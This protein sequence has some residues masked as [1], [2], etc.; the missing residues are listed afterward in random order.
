MERAF[1]ALQE[2]RKAAHCQGALGISY[3]Q[4]SARL[5]PS[6]LLQVHGFSTKDQNSHDVQKTLRILLVTLTSPLP[7]HMRR[8][9]SNGLKDRY[10]QSLPVQSTQFSDVNAVVKTYGRRSK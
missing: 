6:L 5:Q 1:T 4:Y 8:H 9:R 2:T 10:V 7:L 3:V